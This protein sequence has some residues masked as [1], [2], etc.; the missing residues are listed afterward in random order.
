[1]R[2]DDRRDAGRQLAAL[3]AE[4]A[5]GRACRPGAAARVA[6]RSA[7]EVARRLAAPLDLVMV[8]KIGAPGHEELA[9]GAVV[10][11]DAAGAGAERPR[12]FAATA[13][14]QAYLERQQALQLAEIERRRGA[15]SRPAAA[16]GRGRADRDRGRR[17][18]RHRR[19]RAGGPARDPPCRAP[20]SSCWRCRWPTPPCSS[21]W[22]RRPTG[23]SACTGRATCSRSGSYYRDFSQ[24]ERRRGGGAAGRGDAGRQRMR[25]VTTHEWPTSVA[26]ARS[27]QQQSAPPS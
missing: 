6:C 17:R 24:V 23:S 14:T 16:S 5:P 4:L 25:A 21:A 19:H 26:D 12:S 27:V 10:D 15:L 13:S 20:A 11:G 7:V 18:H 8:R 9:A 2:F 1:M 22:R 3:L